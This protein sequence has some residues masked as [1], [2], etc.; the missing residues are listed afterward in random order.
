MLPQAF[1]G[2][3]LLCDFFFADRIDRETPVE[4]PIG[5]YLP[6]LPEFCVGAELDRD[7]GKPE[8]EIRQRIDDLAKA[9]ARFDD[10]RPSAPPPL[11][12]RVEQV[13]ERQTHA[14]VPL[15]MVG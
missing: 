6:P 3:F 11:G 9:A 15:K 2:K 8:E 1:A 5:A 14:Q 12:Q 10:K 4:H 7:L 13:V